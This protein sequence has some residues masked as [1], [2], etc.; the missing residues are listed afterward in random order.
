MNTKLFGAFAFVLGATTGSI[1]TWKVLEKKYDERLQEEIDDVKRAYS[2]KK[3]AA[4][5]EPKEEKMEDPGTEDYKKVLVEQG[6][7]TKD[8]MAEI[9]GGVERV[10]GKPYVIRPEEFGEEDYEIVSLR[11]YDD[12]VLTDEYG[13]EVVE[14]VDDMIGKDSLTHFGEYEDDAVYVR[15]DEREIDYEILKD[16]RKYSDVKNRVYYPGTEG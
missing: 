1:I 5:E 12:G 3:D 2:E 6:Y 11:Y 16:M 8:N 10:S 14:D 13:E 15:N 9:K 4:V 7:T